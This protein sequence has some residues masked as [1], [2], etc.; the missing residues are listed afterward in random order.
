MS[1]VLALDIATVT[2]WALCFPDR[3]LAS[4]SFRC[5]RERAKGGVC[6]GERF[7]GLERELHRILDHY[8]D[9]PLFRVSMLAIEMPFMRGPGTRLLFGLA[10]VAEKFAWSQRLVFKEYTAT[11]VKKA[12]AGHGRATKQEMIEAAEEL[13][14]Y[15]PRDDHEADSLCVAACALGRIGK[16]KPQ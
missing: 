15:R 10:S 9:G 14:I 7:A 3:R 16:D 5:G 4:G 2:G 12:A 8:D 1:L 11:S 6:R 13:W